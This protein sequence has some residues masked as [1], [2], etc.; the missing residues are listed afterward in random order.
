M[1]TFDSPLFAVTSASALPWKASE[2]TVR[3]M[4]SWSSRPVM[5]GDVEAPEIWGTP[6][7]LV[8]LSATGMV[9][10]EESAPTMPE[11]P[12]IETSFLAASMPACGLVWV[13]PVWISRSWPSTPPALLICWAASSM[14][15]SDVW[16]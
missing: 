6:S 8:T 14:P 12:S 2:G 5:T 13:S 1:E 11:T 9:T 10:P 15:F 3:N 4:K 7:L 16:P